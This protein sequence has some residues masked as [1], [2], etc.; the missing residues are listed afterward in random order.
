DVATDKLDL[1]D[2]GAFFTSGGDPFASGTLRLRERG[3]DTILEVRFSPGGLYSP[4][5][6]LNGVDANLLTAGNFIG[7][8]GAS[9]SGI[10]TTTNVFGDLSNGGIAQTGDGANNVLGGTAGND[11]LTGLG[12]NDSLTGNSG[13]DLL[14]GGDGND[15]LSGGQ[16]SDRLIGG[17]GI[18]DVGSWG[19]S[20]N[21]A[22]NL[23]NLNSGSA[24]SIDGLD[25]DVFDGIERVAG[26][27]A[28]DV[29][30]GGL[31]YIP[32]ASI[33]DPNENFTGNSGSDV[34]DGQ[35]GDGFLSFAIFAGTAPVNS[36]PAGGV[37]V[38]LGEG[39]AIDNWGN[40]DAV[41][42]IEGVIGSIFNDTLIGGSDSRN[43]AGNLFEDFRPVAGA[44]F[45]DGKGGIDRVTYVGDAGR[46]VG[47]VANLGSTGF[48]AGGTIVDPGTVRDGLG[49]GLGSV[50]TMVNVEWV[51]GS[52]QADTI[53]G[54]AG[55]SRLEGHQGNDF[56][57]GG[58]GIDFVGFV[59]ASS[60]VTANMSTSSGGG[61]GVDTYVNM[62]GLRGGEFNDTL[63]GG[64]GNDYFDGFIGADVISGGGGVDTYFLRPGDGGITQNATD[65]WSFDGDDTVEL[66]QGLTYASLTITQSG[67]DAVIQHTS[68]SEYLAVLLNTSIASLTAD[69]FV[70]QF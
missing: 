29:M 3:P 47:I 57:D 26:S 14:D 53:I 40:L 20:L 30:V 6:V 45:V 15:T 65:V 67:A 54:G 17:A 11:S 21:G 52:E 44:D 59:T 41:F 68:T 32:R 19:T 42:N 1:S 16:G 55:N 28:R 46:T 50:D 31:D 25:Q 56:I 69:R 4:L 22:G 70:D 27:N 18:A 35:E 48:D 12:G 62:E 39:W 60:G 38:N 9:P 49:G 8:G 33:N 7:I 10:A 5:V 37:Q 63:T 66:E 58:A 2:S 64:T 36:V 61:L 51:R 34:I 43:I 24:W 13:N 23:I